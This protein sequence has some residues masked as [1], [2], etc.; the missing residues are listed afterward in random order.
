M[1]TSHRNRRLI[2]CL[3]GI[4]LLMAA[5]APALSHLLVA[6]TDHAVFMSDIC[7]TAGNTANTPESPD[8]PFNHHDKGDCPYCQAHTDSLLTQNQPSPAHYSGTA[9]VMP[10]FIESPQLGISWPLFHPRGPPELSPQAYRS[11]KHQYTQ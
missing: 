7:S 6:K 2:A 8:K 9:T 3:A 1:L 4:A 5:L 11:I 10:L